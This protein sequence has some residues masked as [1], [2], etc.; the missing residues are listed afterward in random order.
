MQTMLLFFWRVNIQIQM[1][2]E[3]FRLSVLFI[4]NR[5]ILKSI[6]WDIYVR[7]PSLETLSTVEAEEERAR[8]MESRPLTMGGVILHKV[9]RLLCCDHIDVT[10]LEKQT[11]IHN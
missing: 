1:C 2:S 11:H 6:E 3:T 9:F 4:L 8:M 7:D 5:A 10:H